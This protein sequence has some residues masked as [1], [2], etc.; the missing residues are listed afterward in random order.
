[1][2]DDIRELLCPSGTLRV[3]INLSN[4]LLVSGGVVD[5][6]PVGVAPDMAA[7]IAQKLDVDITYHCYERPHLLANDAGNDVWDIG[8]IGAEKQRAES[9][10]FTSAY[11]EIESTYLVPANSPLKSIADVD[12]PGVKI[13]VAEK[14][15][16]GLWLDLHIKQ[17][18]LVYASS[19]D[20]SRD[21]FLQ[22]KLDA[23]AGLRPKLIADQAIIEGSQ[24]IPG[25]FSTVQQAIGT[26][27]SKARATEFLQQ[28]VDDAISGGLVAALIEKHQVIG[29]SVASRS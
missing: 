5:G 14:T 10:S 20:A 22:N 12:Q 17:A 18:E 4:F 29:L 16:Y 7:S 23:L 28:F 6:T 25:Y 3:G 2:L 15:A 9:I 26:P 24:I 11:S 1:M 8:L 21:L 27:I 13:A 19:L